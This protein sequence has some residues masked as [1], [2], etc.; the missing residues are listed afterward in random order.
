MTYTSKNERELRE[1]KGSLLS[2]IASEHSLIAA[3]LASILAGT[4]FASGYA[5]VADGGTIAHGLGSTPSVVIVTGSVAGQI[6]TATAG[7][8]NI[9]VAI[10]TNLGAAGTTQVVSW[11][12]KL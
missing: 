7:A 9:T 1:Q 11:M 8:A 6:I 4:G 12:A 3:E 2:K 5:S 10:K